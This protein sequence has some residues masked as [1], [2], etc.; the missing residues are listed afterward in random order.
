M[1]TGQTQDMGER[2]MDLARAKEAY[3][4]LAQSRP[5]AVETL[6]FARSD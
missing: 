1:V 2:A 3:Q 5:N 6:V 4:L